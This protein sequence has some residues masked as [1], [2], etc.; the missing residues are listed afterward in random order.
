LGRDQ[1][2]LDALIKYLESYFVGEPHVQLGIWAND[3]TA[4]ASAAFLYRKAD[5][6]ILLS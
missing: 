6:R 3:A 2:E 4:S 1:L 5:G